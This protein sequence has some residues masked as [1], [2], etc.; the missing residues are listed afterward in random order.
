MKKMEG[1]AILCLLLVFAILLGLGLFTYRIETR[2][3]TWAAFYANSHIYKDGVLTIGSITDRNG[4]IL[5][6]NTKEGTKYSEDSAIRKSTMQLVGDP[7][8]NVATA[9]NVV[10]KGKLIGYD[11]VQGTNGILKKKG[12]KITL[13]IDS[14]INKVAYEALGSRDGFVSVYNWRMG[15]I[16]CLISNPTLDPE[17]NVDP[18]TQKEGTYI[19]K[20]FSSTFTPGSIFKLV[21]MNAV[22]ENI[23]DLDSW[24]FTCD[25]ETEIGGEKITCPRHHG[26]QNIEDALANSCNCA[27]ASLAVELGTDTMEKNVKKLGLTDSYDIDG[28]KTKE[29]SFNFDTYDINLGWAGIGQFEDQINPLSMMVYMGAIAGGGEAATPRLVIDDGLVEKNAKKVQLLKY[30]NAVKLQEMMRNNVEKTYGESNFPNLDIHAKSGTAE[31]ISGVKPHAWF[32][33]YA[34]DYAFVVCVE[35]GGYGSTVAGPIANSVLQ[36]IKKTYE[37]TD[38]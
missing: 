26:K 1:R 31:T 17:S 11:R 22:L 27:F 4:I 9:I 13:S 36:A 34:G 23:D 3:A 8:G 21:T 25:G 16:I 35:N 2:G 24:E 38:N 10:L 20:V 33:G 37:N 32:S 14:D 12:G 18:S 30:E 6:K 28:I 7:K 19:N 5:L 29:G 15:D